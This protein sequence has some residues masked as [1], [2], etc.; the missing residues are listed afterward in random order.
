MRQHDRRV[1]RN[2]KYIPTIGENQALA[3][4]TGIDRRTTPLN[5]S[6]DNR[7]VVELDEGLG[8]EI[9]LEAITGINPNPAIERLGYSGTRV[10]K[11]V[12][13]CVDQNLVDNSD[14]DFY[15]TEVLP[16]L[17]ELL[18]R[19]PVFMDWWFDGSRFL[20]FNGDTWQSP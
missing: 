13:L 10:H 17:R 3:G 11:A 1:D 18:G 2:S 7:Y 14:T 20:V 4:S 9:D 5:P 16:R 8:A 6:N 15:A 19:D 12:F